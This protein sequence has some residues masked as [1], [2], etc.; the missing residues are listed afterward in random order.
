MLFKD[1]VFNNILLE[2]KFQKALEV[3]QKYFGEKY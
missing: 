2:T 1:V 3:N